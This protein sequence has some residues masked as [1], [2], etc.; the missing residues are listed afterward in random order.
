[1]RRS[2][3]S[4]PS[5]QGAVVQKS[6]NCDVSA[7]VLFIGS[8]WVISDFSSA[9]SLH[10]HRRWAEILF[11]RRLCNW[12]GA[13]DP[14]S[15]V[16]IWFGHCPVPSFKLGTG[17]LFNPYGFQIGIIL[18]LKM[19]FKSVCDCR[20]HTAPIPSRWIAVGPNHSWK[21]FR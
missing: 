8:S 9:L 2:Q 21:V 19:P 15:V 6:I 3:R 1:L 13:C 4:P 10:N 16:P 17:Q 5:M 20:S 12:S 18:F 7:L 14:R 11:L